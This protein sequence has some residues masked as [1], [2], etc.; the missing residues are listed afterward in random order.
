MSCPFKKNQNN[1]HQSR[2]FY[3]ALYLFSLGRGRTP[4]F[5]FPSL[6]TSADTAAVA[7]ATTYSCGCDNM[8][9]ICGVGPQRASQLQPFPVTPSTV[10]QRLQHGPS[11]SVTLKITAQ[12]P[13]CCFSV[14]LVFTAARQR[15]AHLPFQ[16]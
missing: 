13:K 16:A 3:C 6:C 10:G 4:G 8:V 12:V 7:L 2:S 1:P 15:N 9:G 14:S 11:S 5:N